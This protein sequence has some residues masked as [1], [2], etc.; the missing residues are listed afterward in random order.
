MHRVP[1]PAPEKTPVVA[2]RT[3]GGLFGRGRGRQKT[4]IGPVAHPHHSAVQSHAPSRFTHGP[5]KATH[6]SKP[7][8]FE[9]LTGSSS[10]PK[11]DPTVGSGDTKLRPSGTTENSSACSHKRHVT[12]TA[13][14]GAGQWLISLGAQSWVATWR[15][16]GQPYGS[17]SWTD[18]GSLKSV[19]GFIRLFWFIRKP[20]RPMAAAAGRT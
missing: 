20:A 13:K 7:V 16:P 19:S 3:D 17:A 1:G 2:D 4:G 15:A 5:R 9:G 11:A 14:R 18:Q 8:S 12:V 6:L 10:G